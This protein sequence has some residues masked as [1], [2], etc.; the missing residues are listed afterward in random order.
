MPLSS[1]TCGGDPTL[2][3]KMVGSFAAHAQPHLDS[4][5]AAVVG[6]FEIKG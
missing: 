4:L 3:H 6:Q 5:E 2:F 1:S